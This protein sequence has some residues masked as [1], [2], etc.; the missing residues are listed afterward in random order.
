MVFPLAGG[1]PRS[2]AGLTISTP[3]NLEITI[4]R[5]WR[6]FRIPGTGRTSTGI[7]MSMPPQVR[8]IATRAWRPFGLNTNPRILSGQLWPRGDLSTKG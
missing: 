3:L 1:T 7:T 5:S 4:T 2:S 8:F 6:P